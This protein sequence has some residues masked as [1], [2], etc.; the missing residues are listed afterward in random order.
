M[1]LFAVLFFTACSGDDKVDDTGGGTETGDTDTDTTIPS[2][3]NDGDGYADDVDCDDARADVHPGVATDACNGRDDDCDGALDEDPDLLWY[4]DGDGDG[5]GETGSA[6]FVDCDPGVDAYA[7]NQSDCDDGDAS[8]FPGADETCDGL[9]NDCNG[10][11]DDDPA[12]FGTWYPDEDADGFGDSEASAVEGCVPG[13]AWTDNAD[14]CDDRIAS[15]H[16]GA[17]ETCNDL[18]DDC[19]GSVDENADFYEAYY[20]DADGDGAG[21]DTIVYGCDEA[22]AGG[23]T[24]TWDCDDRDVTEPVFVTTSGSSRGDGS[25][26]DPYD[27]IQDAI[28]VSNTCVIVGSGTYNEDIDF[29]GSAITVEGVDGS[30]LTRIVGTGRTSVV[31]INNGELGA[32]LRGFTVSGGAGTP[33]SGSGSYWDGTQTVSYAYSYA[34]G[35]GAYLGWGTEVTLDDVVFES[36]LL[37]A[38]YYYYYSATYYVYGGS[39]GGGVYAYGSTLDMTDVTFRDNTASGGVAFNNQYGTV[40]GTRVRAYDN[41]GDYGTFY[42]YGAT[43]D[44]ENLEINANY[45]SY[46]YAAIYT[47]YSDLSLTNAT[48]VDADYGIYNDYSTMVLDSSVVSGTGYGLYDSSG[49]TWTITYSNIYGNSVD[50]YGVTD[51]TGRSGN[52]SEDPGFVTFSD[53]SDG[54]ND[55]LTL[56]GTS[57]MVDVG[58]PSSA[59]YDVDGSRCDMGAYGGPEGSGW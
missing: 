25:H 14:D 46:G 29:G 56:T 54:T 42:S 59:R 11:V 31:T 55:D 38:Y 4:L 26:D 40:T 30:G 39:Y 27:S 44:W 58:N 16:P 23:V 13:E 57:A 36:N 17:L 9:D 48:L 21:V 12:L 35:G 50:Y 49:A 51:V 52:I 5:F 41:D 37:S 8:I 1:R 15:V 43:E 2:A 7:S 6:S 47:S 33:S 18:D 19:N 22:Q 28:Q 32:T 3:D 24:N 34:Y 45:T 20:E 53:D 10:G